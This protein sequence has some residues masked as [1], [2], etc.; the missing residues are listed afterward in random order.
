MTFA[1]YLHLVNRL[2]IRRAEI[3]LWILDKG[4]LLAPRRRQVMTEIAELMGE[5][6]VALY[7]LQRRVELLSA[8]LHNRE[9]ELKESRR[10]LDNIM[11]T[12]L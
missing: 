9:L 3:D 6:D 10:R 1:E 8:E 2:G 5:A 7:K 12:I 11:Q 4:H